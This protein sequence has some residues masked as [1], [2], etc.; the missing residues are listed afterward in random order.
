MDLLS[1][2]MLS[3]YKYTFLFKKPIV[4]GKIHKWNEE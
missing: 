1:L 4:Y 2:I 3:I